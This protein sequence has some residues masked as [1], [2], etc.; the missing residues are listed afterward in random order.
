MT[1]IA[2]GTSR[3]RLTG[4]SG[5][6]AAGDDTAAVPRTI[7][8]LQYAAARLPFTLLDEYVIARY[9]GQDAPVRVGF[10][11]WLGSL[12]LLAGQLL[13]D[14][15]ISRR[16]EALMGQT[17]DLAQAG[18]QAMDAS[19][20]PTHSGQ[21]PPDLPA[22]DQAPEI[23]PADQAPE[24]R[25]Q[26]TAHQE[27]DDPQQVHQAPGSAMIDGAD[28]DMIATAVRLC[29]GVSALDGGQFGAVATYL[30]GRKVTGVVVGDGWVKV[31]VRSRWG[32]PARELAALI[33]TAAAPFTGHRRLDVVI[34]DIDDP[35][36]SMPAGAG[37]L[38]PDPGLPPV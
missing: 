6:G 37:S 19:A 23:L 2:P 7:V 8:E 24:L 14:D 10:Q 11:R 33:T 25:D 22:A 9:W 3:T 31:Q 4:R 28:V 26:T 13:A 12:D 30:P 20:P 36:A 35:P 27:Q 16:G 1:D 32:I 17:R 15:E 18:G 5:P 21:V 38:R 29:T 34:A